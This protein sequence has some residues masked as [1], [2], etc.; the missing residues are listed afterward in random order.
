MIMCKNKF[1]LVNWR[2]II[3]VSRE[4]ISLVGSFQIGIWMK[5]YLSSR[6]VNEHKFPSSRR[7]SFV[8]VRKSISFVTTKYKYQHIA[9]WMIDSQN[10]WLIHSLTDWE[11][12]W[13]IDWLTQ[14]DWL[15]HCLI[16]WLTPWLIDSLIDWLTD[17]LNDSLIDW[18]IDYI[19]P[20]LAH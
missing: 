10:N 6:F 1:G 9:D 7:S 8:L 19:P 4:T 16:D 13:L 11:T 14:L 20:S 12:Y 15:T 17:W 3:A 2:K 18:W 5:F